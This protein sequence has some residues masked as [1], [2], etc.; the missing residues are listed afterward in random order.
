MFAAR[1]LL[2]KLHA[3]GQIT[4]PPLQAYQCRPPRPIPRRLAWQPPSPWS[5]SLAELG[6]VNITVVQPSMPTARQRAFYLH[7]NHYRSLRLVGQNLRYLARDAHDRD[8]AALLCAARAWRCAPRERA[9]GWADAER[10]VEAQTV[11]EREVNYFATHREHLHYAAVSRG[12]SH[13][14]RVTDNE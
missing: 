3:Q 14:L 9:V 12:S 8:V 2:L 11:L 5:S 7:Q 6:A 4:L 1:S 10:R 13:E